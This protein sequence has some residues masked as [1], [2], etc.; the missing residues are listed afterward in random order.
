LGQTTFNPDSVPVIDG[1]VL[2]STEFETVLNKEEERER[3]KKFL[4]DKL[5]PY[6]GEFILDNKDFTVSRIIDYIDVST[7]ILNTFAM[8]MTYSMSFEYKDSLCTMIIQNIRFMEKE[9]FE[10]KEEAKTFRSKELDMPEYTAEDIM[11]H[12]KYKVLMISKASQKVTDSSIK[13]INEIL[14]ELEII[15]HRKTT[16]V[17]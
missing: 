14:K 8:Y 16:S 10:I 3:V 2:F 17:E 13:R 5:N 6:S 12:E 1:K 9:Y 15:L 11:L 4:N 7:G